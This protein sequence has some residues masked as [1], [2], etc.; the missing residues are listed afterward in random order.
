MAV[1]KVKAKQKDTNAVDF[2]NFQNFDDLDLD[3]LLM[4]R[5]VI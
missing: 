3:G 5:T 2:D 4:E 1:R